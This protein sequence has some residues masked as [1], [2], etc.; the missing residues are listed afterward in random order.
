MKKELSSTRFASITNDTSRVVN[1]W[2]VQKGDLEF[3]FTTTSHRQASIPAK[4]VIISETT[5]GG[6]ATGH[7]YS[8]SDA[9]KSYR[10]EGNEGGE[11]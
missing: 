4:S 8:Q 1:L 3:L 7:L 2:K 6:H 11:L 5:L 10:G 9:R